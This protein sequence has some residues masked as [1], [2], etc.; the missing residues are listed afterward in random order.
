MSV[1]HQSINSCVDELKQIFNR[2]LKS[3]KYRKQRFIYLKNKIF[4]NIMSKKS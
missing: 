1:K 3:Q 4:L 2:K